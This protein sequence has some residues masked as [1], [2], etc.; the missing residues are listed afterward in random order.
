MTYI[1][2]LLG[3][4]TSSPRAALASMMTAPGDSLIT[5][6][7]WHP[8]V[9][10]ADS[11]IAVLLIVGN[12]PNGVRVQQTLGPTEEYTEFRTLLP[13][14]YPSPIPEV[15]SIYVYVGVCYRGRCAGSTAT[16]NLIP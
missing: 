12:V 6:A 16:D 15:Y 11:L 4:L 7:A 3:L 10:P 14:P 8:V 5:R 13:L 9:G 1:M 2:L